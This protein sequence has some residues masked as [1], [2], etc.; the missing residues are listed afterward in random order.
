MQDEPTHSPFP[1]TSKF[2]KIMNNFSRIMQTNTRVLGLLAAFLTLGIAS[3]ALAAKPADISF[4]D[5]KIDIDPASRFESSM[6]TDD[7]EQL[8]GQLVRIRGYMWPSFKRTG[9]K[10]FV[11]LLNTQCKYGSAK[12]PIWCNIRV[13]MDEGETAS[14]ST[15]PMTLEG[16]LHV[17]LVKGDKY[18][19]SLYKMEDARVVN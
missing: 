12:D 9:I 16:R 5:L 19:I 1:R 10:A 3:T 18:D 17:D 4:D 7:I 6:L 8:D 14:Y 11:L 15:R 13:T 2:A